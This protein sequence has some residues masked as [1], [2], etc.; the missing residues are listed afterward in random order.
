M[1]AQEDAAAYSCDAAPLPAHLPPLP[2]FPHAPQHRTP[3]PAIADPVTHLL[4]LSQ[5]WNL[6]PKG[7]MKLCYLLENKSVRPSWKH[8][9]AP[10]AAAHRLYVALHAVLPN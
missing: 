3:N 9:A 5:E 2:I 8:R 6:M 1:A 4:T 7:P 10:L